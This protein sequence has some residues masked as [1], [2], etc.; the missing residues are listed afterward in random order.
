MSDFPKQ[1]KKAPAPTAAPVNSG[2]PSQKSPVTGQGGVSWG[3]PGAGKGN[4]D[5]NNPK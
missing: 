1:G 2:K 3:G 4:N 5:K